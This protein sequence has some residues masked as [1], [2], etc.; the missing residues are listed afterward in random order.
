MGL[1][2]D[3]PLGPGGPVY[4]WPLSADARRPSGLV[5]HCAI[6]H[7][8]KEDRSWVLAET[9]RGPLP[10]TG[11][12]DPFPRGWFDDQHGFDT[13]ARLVDSDVWLSLRDGRVIAI[14]TPVDSAPDGASCA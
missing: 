11:A 9:P 13:F 7:Y 12:G 8:T 14:F 6:E 1:V 4:G 10:H 2:D 3:A 5:F